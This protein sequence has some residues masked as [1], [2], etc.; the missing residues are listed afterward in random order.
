[1][2]LCRLSGPRRPIPPRR[3]SGAFRIAPSS[4]RRPSAPR[5]RPRRLVGDRQAGEGTIGAQMAGTIAGI[6]GT[7]LVAL[8]IGGNIV[9][10]D[11]A[12]SALSSVIAGWHIGEMSLVGGPDEI[13]RRDW[14]L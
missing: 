8:N 2:V 11:F 12:M 4:W 6:A 10:I 9:G 5:P 7:V 3:K 13:K 14:A 1:M